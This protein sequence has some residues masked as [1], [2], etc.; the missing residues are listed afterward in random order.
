MGGEK[1]AAQWKTMAHIVE[2]LLGESY[3]KT[4][5]SRPRDYLSSKMEWGNIWVLLIKTNATYWARTREEYGNATKSV[6]RT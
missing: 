1:C 6:R 2:H 3:I 4:T 5:H